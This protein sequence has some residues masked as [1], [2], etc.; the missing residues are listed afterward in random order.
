MK[1]TLIKTE[2]QKFNDKILFDYSLK[3]LTSLKIGGNSE[4]FFEPKN[5]EELISTLLFFNNK[6]IPISIIGGGTNLLISDNGV[7]GLVLHLKNFNTIAIEEKNDNTVFVRVGAGVLTDDLTKWAIENSIS[8]FENFGGLPGTIGGAAFMNARCY[9]K[10]I[11]D[12]FVSAKVLQL[13]KQSTNISATVNEY[14]FCT[15]DW[16]YKKSP[17]QKAAKGI[18]IQ[19]NR[20]I[21]L[22]VLFKVENG[23]RI[24]IEEKTKTRFSDRIQKGHFKAFSAGSTFKNNHNFGKPS[25]KII[26]EAGL[27]GFSIGN[28]QV[29]PWHG[30]FLINTGSASSK[31]MKDLIE[32]VQKTVLEKTDM[33]LEPEVILAGHF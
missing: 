17:F 5:E 21:I 28:A 24:E 8:G 14:E 33:L 30:N 22:S 4:F 29:A 7:E 3:N 18:A 23:D 9:D 27:K 31:D 10:S 19:E 2:I 11:S 20:Y 6:N 13:K 32:Y 25:G 15:E 1:N 26:E 12:L 16:D